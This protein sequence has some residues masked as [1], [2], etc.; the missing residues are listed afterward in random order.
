MAAKDLNEDG[1]LSPDEYLLGGTLSP[2]ANGCPDE[3]GPR[4][5]CAEGTCQCHWPWTGLDCA[6]SL[7]SFGS[8]AAEDACRPWKLC[9]ES[10]FEALAGT[11]YTD[12]ECSPYT[13]CKPD[14][15]EVVPPGFDHDRTCA[16]L[17]QCG[18]EEF[19]ARPPDKSA[20]RLCLACRVCAADEAETRPCS[21]AQDR[22]CGE[23][24]KYLAPCQASVP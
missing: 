20:D 14:E 9:N 10:S 22:L 15:Y 3:C 4:Q 6:E 19:E 8:Y 11:A 2:P 24:S 5:E 13:Q 16:T 17:T 1:M 21:D 12:R 23:V 7:C 18:G